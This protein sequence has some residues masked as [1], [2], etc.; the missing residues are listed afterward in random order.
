MGRDNSLRKGTE[1][2]HLGQDGA[3]SQRNGKLEAL[4]G[5]V[6]K[7][8]EGACGRERGSRCGRQ[9]RPPGT[10]FS[11]MRTPSIRFHRSGE[12]APSEELVSAL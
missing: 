11:G 1:G 10:L 9:L 5:H 8:A 12:E 3:P 2:G 6:A 7:G 4:L